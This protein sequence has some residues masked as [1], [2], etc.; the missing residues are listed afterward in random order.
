MPPSIY[1]YQ[2]LNYSMP[3]AATSSPQSD[4][5]AKLNPSHES[6]P[7]VPAQIRRAGI[8]G[9]AAQPDASP[10]WMKLDDLVNQPAGAAAATSVV[11]NAEMCQRYLVTP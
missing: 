4:N 3:D 5:H 11:A 10:T 9:P 8:V 2:G 6:E 7:D 1:H